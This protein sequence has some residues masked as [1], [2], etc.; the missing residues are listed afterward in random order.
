MEL[1]VPAETSGVLDGGGRIS[2][3]TVTD[4]SPELAEVVRRYRK[5]IAQCFRR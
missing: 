1:S 2:A 3:F 4:V 5:D